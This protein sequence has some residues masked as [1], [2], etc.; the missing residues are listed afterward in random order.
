MR[1]MLFSIVWFTIGVLQMVTVSNEKEKE[2]PD[3][4]YMILTGLNG[5]LSMT[6]GC[7]Y[8]LDI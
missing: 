8:Q 2:K 6:L 4:F 1:K 3:K 5:I 7:L